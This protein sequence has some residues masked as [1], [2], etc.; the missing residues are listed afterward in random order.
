MRKLR[1][2]EKEVRGRTMTQVSI[3]SYAGF[4]LSHQVP[5]AIQL[6]EQY[7]LQIPTK[8]GSIPPKDLRLSS[9]LSQGK[10]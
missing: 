10:D 8:S 5:Y 2:R 3:H 4:I 9:S 7:I 6:N 1:F